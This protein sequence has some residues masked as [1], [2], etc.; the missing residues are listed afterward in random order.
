MTSTNKPPAGAKPLMMIG[1]V[2]AGKSTLIKA[3]ELGGSKAPS[4]SV[5]KTEAIT[6][7]DLAIDTP[8][9]MITIPHFFNALILNSIRARLVVFLMDASRPSQLP[10]R[11]ALAMKAPSVGVINKIDVA[12]EGGLRKARAALTTAWVKD[13]FEI[14][15]VTGQGLDEF[16]EW[17]TRSRAAGPGAAG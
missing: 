16:K 8:G 5:K 12:A 1:P 10:S 6:Y 11:L 7:Y 13:I 3:L 17:I 15:A 2:G 9:E 14:S 4:A